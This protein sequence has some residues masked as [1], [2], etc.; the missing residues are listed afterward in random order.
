MNVLCDAF[1]GT[2]FRLSPHRHV[3]LSRYNNGIASFEL[4]LEKAASEK[5]EHADAG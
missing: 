3:G 2:V 4:T 5:V 1:T